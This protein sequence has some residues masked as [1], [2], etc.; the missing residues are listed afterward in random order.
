MPRVQ[1]QGASGQAFFRVLNDGSE[2]A[3][4]ITLEGLDLGGIKGSPQTEDDTD[5]VTK[6]HIHQAP[7]GETGH[8][9]LNIFGAP[10][11][12]DDDMEFNAATGTI[13]GVWDNGDANDTLDEHAQS[14]ALA[15]AISA[16]CAGETYLNIHTADFDDGIIR[17][18]IL[19]A[20][21]DVCN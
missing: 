5:D 9:V 11:E 3:Y 19:P 14:V 16:L 2:L 17:G 13:T 7:E 4:E 20:D 21:S 15:D 10:A 1:D 18:Q 8:H 6:I 12:D